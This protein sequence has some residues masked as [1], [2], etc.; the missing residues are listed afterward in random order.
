MLDAVP[1]EVG[2]INLA[3]R[4][5][6][7]LSGLA[8]TWSEVKCA[9]Y[10]SHSWQVLEATR[11]TH[12]GLQQSIRDALRGNLWGRYLLSADPTHSPGRQKDRTH[13]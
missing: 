7:L 1:S 11:A 5:A 10:A 6:N 13:A 9:A 8:P 4:L 12:G 2:T 3:D